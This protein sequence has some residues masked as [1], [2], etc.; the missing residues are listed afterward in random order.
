MDCKCTFPIDSESNGITLGAKSIEKVK[1]QS[2]F[3]LDR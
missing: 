2:K 1:L 3:G